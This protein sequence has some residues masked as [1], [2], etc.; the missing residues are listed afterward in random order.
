MWTD[1]CTLLDRIE[2]VVNEPEKV[3]ALCQ[4]RFNIARRNGL[5]VRYL[6]PVT[7]GDQ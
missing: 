7:A 5:E 4:E 6:G 1:L 2:V 3:Y